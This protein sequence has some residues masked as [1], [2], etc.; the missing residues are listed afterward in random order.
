MTKR[1]KTLQQAANELQEA[2]NRLH[3][4]KRA[5]LESLFT[6]AVFNVTKGKGE[7]TKIEDF[8]NNLN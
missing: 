5:Y 7:Q 4:A 3:D 2:L 6:S 1:T 8:V